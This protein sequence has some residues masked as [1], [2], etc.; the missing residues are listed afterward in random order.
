MKHY[1]SKN[2]I[3]AGNI[4]GEYYHKKFIEFQAKSGFKI[5]GGS[6]LSI[7]S[8][9]VKKRLVTDINLLNSKE[10]KILIM[11]ELLLNN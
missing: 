6:E 1:N 8:E 3:N 2:I 4:I 11:N 5:T 9:Q 7:G 10:R